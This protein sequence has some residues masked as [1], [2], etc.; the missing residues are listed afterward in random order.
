MRV[1]LL[2]ALLLQLALLLATARGWSASS[3]RRGSSAHAP[4]TRSAV[5][6]LQSP[7]EDAVTPPEPSKELAPADAGADGAALLKRGKGGRFKPWKPKDNRDTLLYD[8]E[9]MTL[10]ESTRIGLFR[11]PSA[12]CGDIIAVRDRTFVIKQLSWKYALRGGRYCMV[13]KAAKVKQTAR[14]GCDAWLDHCLEHR[15]LDAEP[16]VAPVAPRRPG[17]GRGGDEHDM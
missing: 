12:G 7:D 8:V 4:T 17:A 11:L 1:R 16:A 14:D 3:T 10:P 9:E 15:T 2:P 6:A 13:A 5:R